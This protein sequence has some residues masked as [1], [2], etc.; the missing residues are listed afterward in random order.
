M[1][2][3]TRKELKKRII[4]NFIKFIES[5]PNLTNDEMIK[6]AFLKLKSTIKKDET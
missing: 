4:S 2:K 6:D 5:H 1:E 3:I